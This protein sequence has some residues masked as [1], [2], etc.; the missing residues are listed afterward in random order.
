[1][2][3]IYAVYERNGYIE[4]ECLDTVYGWDE[5]IM[6]IAELYESDKT[7]G[8]LGKYYYLCK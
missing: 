4:Q 6:K 7:D 2:Y 8:V 5:A 3:Y 1:M